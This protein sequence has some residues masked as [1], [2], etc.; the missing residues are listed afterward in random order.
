MNRLT[1]I[2][3]VCLTTLMLVSCGSG[4]D[5]AEEKEANAALTPEVIAAE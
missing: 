1:G 4:E 5:G 3:S 2:C